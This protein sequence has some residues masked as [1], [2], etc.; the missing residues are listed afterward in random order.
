M[1][2]SPLHKLAQM[3][4]D[5]RLIRDEDLLDTLGHDG[6]IT[7]AL[8]GGGERLLPSGEILT[9]LAQGVGMPLDEVL[10]RSFGLT[11]DEIDAASEFIR[12][13]QFAGEDLPTQNAV[14]EEQP[15]QPFDH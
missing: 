11:P 2:V 8:E 4:R 10:S 1:R 14:V 3:I 15:F 6:T 12:L 9:V 7:V 5:G 13:V